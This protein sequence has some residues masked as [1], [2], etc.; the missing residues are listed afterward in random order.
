[1]LQRCSLLQELTVELA[2]CQGNK[3]LILQGKDDISLLVAL[4]TND[5]ALLLD[6]DGE[7]LLLAF[8]ILEDELEDTVDLATYKLD[9]MYTDDHR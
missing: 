6:I 9:D 5:L 2:G 1:M 3:V 7:G 8:A 4:S